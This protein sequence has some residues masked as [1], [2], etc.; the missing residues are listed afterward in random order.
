MKLKATKK[1]RFLI[2]ALVFSILLVGIVV[3]TYQGKKKAEQFYSATFKSKVVGCQLLYGRTLEFELENQQTI[4]FFPPVGNKLKIGDLIVKD[5]YTS[6]YTV[7]R[8]NIEGEYEFYK[9]YDR[10]VIE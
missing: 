9:T 8:K 5:K 3:D 7:L 4:F 1:N 10:E 6:K 2:L